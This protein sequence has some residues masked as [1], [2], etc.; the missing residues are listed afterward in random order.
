MFDRASTG[1]EATTVGMAIPAVSLNPDRLAGAPDA[2]R[3]ELEPHNR[4]GGAH[5]RTR[6][7][8]R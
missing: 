6:R 5:R 1:G 2:E 8:P 4:L 7:E 3:G